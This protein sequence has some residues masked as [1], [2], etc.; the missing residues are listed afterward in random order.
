MIGK[1]VTDIQSLLEHDDAISNLFVVF[2]QH[3]CT[4]VVVAQAS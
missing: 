1:R 2:L 3:A 4:G